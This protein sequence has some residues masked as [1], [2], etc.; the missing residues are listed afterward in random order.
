MQKE[1][2]RL[3]RENNDLE[4]KVLV[5]QKVQEFHEKGKFSIDIK[6]R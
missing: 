4:K 3:L 1:I 6:I 5:Q 2:K